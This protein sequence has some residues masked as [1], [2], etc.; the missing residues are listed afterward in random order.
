MS[1]MTALMSEWPTRVRT[2]VPPCS[3]ITSGTAL[4]QMRLCRI[5]A[6]GCWR[7]ISRGHDG[8]GERARHQLALVVDQ[9]DP[10]GVAVEGQPT[11]APVAST[12]ACRSTQVL[13]LDGVGR[14]VRE[15]AVELAV[16][17]LDARRAGRR[18]RPARS[19]RPCRWRCRPRSC[20]GFSSS[21]ST[22]VCTWATKSPSASRRLT[23]P[24]GGR[25]AGTPVEGHLA[26]RVEAGVLADRSGPGQAQLDAVVLR[27][28]CATRSASPRARRSD[29]R[30]RTAGRS[31]PGRGR[32]RRGPGW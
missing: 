24:A 6:P 28:G 4:E 15:G 16:E 17:D 18:T 12:R 7:S 26:D 32:R 10:V 30:R 23:V 20:S 31:R 2:G 21:T 14:V 22:K 1:A 3:R 29:P 8:G 13:G 5:V 11:S 19:A 9:E 27:P 25:P